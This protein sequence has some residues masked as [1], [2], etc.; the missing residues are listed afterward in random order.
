MSFNR[1]QINQILYQIMFFNISKNII[2]YV[3]DNSLLKEE[4]N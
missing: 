2:L 3:L 1:N 4:L